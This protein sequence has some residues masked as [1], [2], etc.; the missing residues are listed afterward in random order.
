MNQVPVSA[1]LVVAVL[2]ADGWHR[3]IPGTFTIGRLWPTGDHRDTTG[4]RFEEADDGNPYRPPILAGPVDAILAVR[5]ITPRASRRSAEVTR[6][7]GAR[8]QGSRR[9]PCRKANGE[10]ATA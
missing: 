4:Y 8:P 2:L 9:D 3:V 5:Q 7:S 10:P 1:D 6:M